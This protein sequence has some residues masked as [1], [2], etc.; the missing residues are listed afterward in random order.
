MVLLVV[1]VL[2][3]VVLMLVISIDSCYFT[4]PD[5]D[6]PIWQLSSKKGILISSFDGKSLISIIRRV[7]KSAWQIPLVLKAM[8]VNPDMKMLL[9]NTS[10]KINMMLSGKIRGYESYNFTIRQLLT[11]LA[12]LDAT[13]RNDVI[14]G[15]KD[16]LFRNFGIKSLS[17]IGVNVTALKSRSSNVL[18][19]LLKDLQVLRKQSFVE[20]Y[21][22]KVYGISPQ[23]L[24]LLRSKADGDL[25]EKLFQTARDNLNMKHHKSSSKP[26]Q[27][28]GVV[29]NFGKRFAQMPFR[30]IIR[31]C[32]LKKEVLVNSSVKDL[33]RRCLNMTSS[34]DLKGSLN[35]ST[36]LKPFSLDVPLV[37]L[38]RI[39]S[40]DADRIDTSISSFV[41]AKTQSD[42]RSLFIPLKVIFKAGGLRMDAARNMTLLMLFRTP[43][44]SH[45]KSRDYIKSSRILGN[46]L[47]I[48]KDR[49]IEDLVKAVGI[50]D[51]DLSNTSSYDLLKKSILLLK[52]GKIY[53]L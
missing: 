29:R 24:K 42:I 51:K 16:F 9:N 41:N 6:I 2:V 18:P 34:T 43:L 26:F 40:M 5:F 23:M 13:A 17:A 47:K 10:K 4:D 48:V 49:T 30:D 15:L 52:T 44:F 27:L 19:A 7:T 50:K 1:V 45:F 11:E 39:L 32:H 22:R 8:K 25:G 3:V 53:V 20:K 12:K 36:L 21:F 35:V 14:E 38:G 33:F 46:N 28:R 37:E 31:A